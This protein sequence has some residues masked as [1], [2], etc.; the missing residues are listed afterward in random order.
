MNEDSRPSIEDVYPRCVSAL[1]KEKW[2]ELFKEA[3]DY[4]QVP[5]TI[6][7]AV[8]VPQYAADLA[9]VELAKYEAATAPRPTT[10]GITEA[11]IN[12]TLKAVEVSHRHLPQWVN[13]GKG[14][15]PEAGTEV[16]LAWRGPR[17]GRLY[18][19]AASS[20]DLLVL[21]MLAEGIPAA[22]VASAGK[23]SVGAVERAVFRAADSG[24]V[25]TPPSLIRRPD[26][27]PQGEIEPGRFRESGSFT[28]QWHLTQACDL[29]CAHCYDRSDRK[30]LPLDKAYEILAQLRQFCTDRRVEG[31]VSLSGGNPLL[32]P[33]F[34]EVYARAV[35]LGF[36][37]GVMGNPTSRAMLQRMIDIEMPSFYQI[38]LEG[39]EERNDA[40]RGKGHFKRSLEFLKLLKDMGISNM[41]MLTLTAD[42]VDD[43]IPLGLKLEGLADSFNFNRLS[44]VGEG[45]S[46][47]LPD[48]ERLREFLKEYLDTSREHTHMRLKD[49]LFNILLRQEGLPPDGGCTGFGCGAAFNFVTVL[50]DGEVHACRKFPSLIGNLYE[51]T[52]AE[53]YDSPT[54]ERYRRGCAECEPCPIRPVCGG[55]LAVSHGLGIDALTQ[56]D[57]CCFFDSTTA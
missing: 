45:A 57:R 47:R 50:P 36:E 23:L 41:V 9:R 30:P 13:E 49:N 51:N 10:E 8:G 33:H 28:L 29:H 34:F 14:P 12:P 1:G 31:Q 27:F 54:A 3:A 40:V 4:T 17:T 24:L 44:Q 18:V 53:I 32:Y 21:K 43:V 20:R 55:C 56:K 2:A 35:E 11:V 6:A 38:S 7:T 16:V 26:D 5:D 48:K 19:R 15:E 39:L 42:N 52:L 37:V 25:I 46:L 22:D